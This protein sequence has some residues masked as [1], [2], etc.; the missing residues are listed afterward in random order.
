MSTPL[1]TS[2]A[3]FSKPHTPIV[4]SQQATT[5]HDPHEINSNN[6]N[7]N[8]NNGSSRDISGVSPAPSSQNTSAPLRRLSKANEQ[9]TPCR[10]NRIV[11][12]IIHLLYVAL[13]ARVIFGWP[14]LS[15]ML[16]KDNA[17]IW[18]CE[19]QPRVEGMRYSC[20][21]QDSSVQALFTLGIGIS[22][23]CSLLSGA[24]LDYAGPKITACVGQ[25][26]SVIGWVL[27]SFASEKNQLYIHSVV[28]MALGAD[29]GYLPSMNISNLFPG[30]EQ[31]IIIT[32]CAAM[33]ISFSIT[34]ILDAIW[35][36]YPSLTF[37]RVCLLYA[38]CG[39]GSCFLIS[40]FCIPYK[41]YKSQEEIT[42][43]Y[44]KKIKNTEETEKNAHEQ[45]S[46]SFLSQLLSIHFILMWI[47]WP[48]N[49]LFYNFYLT[50]AENLFGK[51]I[52]NIIGIL[53]P[54][55]MVPAVLFGFV[56]EKYGVMSLVLFI[57]SSG[58]CMYITAL[59]P[60]KAA[61]Y[62][63]PIFSC[64]Y[65]S[66]FSGQMYAYVG[67]TFKCT[68]F[69]RVVGIISITGGLVG[70][71]TVPINN[72]LTLEVFGGN[73]RYTAA[74]ML[75]V[76]VLCLGIAVWLLFVKRKQEKAFIKEEELVLQRQEEKREQEREQ[77]LRAG[78][79]SYA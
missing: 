73:Y 11:L 44:L 58:V 40:L 32:V 41:Q 75:G 37:S 29:A 25:M 2:G 76:A 23:C 77:I 48:L 4:G 18:K 3:F 61:H 13:S 67:D 65:V 70:L 66:N 74:I 15:N 16:L 39:A 31:L 46:A 5:A 34:S 36:A 71:L 9:P 33:S 56:A 57:I 42:Q 24:L 26:C 27:L 21:A 12:L 54:V 35:K 43:S 72:K 62:I 52:N 49:A 79:A 28:L 1:P 30:Y 51:D 22:F 6:N 50:S 60:Y 63:S 59:I 14:H 38:V 10:M 45:Q 64:L 69:G 53:G 7:N 55:S 17:Y 68:D 8:I 19:G 47:Y 78:A 20:T